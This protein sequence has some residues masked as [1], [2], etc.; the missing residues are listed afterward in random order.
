[1]LEVSGMPLLLHDEPVLEDGRVIGF[2]TSGGY[3]PR[4]GLH[5]AFAYVALS[6]KPLLERRFHVNVAGQL[7][8]A[9]ARIE[10]VFDPKQK[11]M[12]S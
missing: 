11:M 5:L 10:P 7:Y 2:T 3:G 8:S 1:M 4:T 9:I 6:D 12:Q